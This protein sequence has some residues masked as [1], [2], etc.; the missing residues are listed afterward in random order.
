MEPLWPHI[1][2]AITETVVAVAAIGGIVAK[3]SARLHDKLDG[4]LDKIDTA[5]QTQALSD[6]Q[7]LTE[8]AHLKEGQA[9][10]RRD[11]HLHSEADTANFGSLNV[12]FEGLR[13]ELAMRRH[14]GQPAVIG[15]Q[16]GSGV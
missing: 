5:V 2:T 10:A 16:E 15:G 11:L 9:E 8:I 7:Q 13:T 4:R 12:R 3:V 1:I 14:A 6:V